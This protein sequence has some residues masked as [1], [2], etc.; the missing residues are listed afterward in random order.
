MVRRVSIYDSLGTL[1]ELD[2][3][4]DEL[5]AA[6]ERTAEPEPAPSAVHRRTL[7][8]M[9]ELVSLGQSYSGPDTPLALRATMTVLD[10][11]RPVMLDMMR[12]IEPRQLAAFMAELAARLQSIADE[13]HPEQDHDSRVGGMVEA[14][15]DESDTGPAQP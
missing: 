8:V 5:T 11:G 14:E 1:A 2:A 7:D 15:H 6:A 4:G 12:K 3:Y 13:Y 9:S 10:R